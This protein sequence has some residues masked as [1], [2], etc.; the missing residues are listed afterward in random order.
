MMGLRRYDVYIHIQNAQCLARKKKSSP[1]SPKGASFDIWISQGPHRVVQRA[2]TGVFL[3]SSKNLELSGR[4]P[5]FSNRGLAGTFAE[6]NS[7]LEAELPARPFAI[8]A[9]DDLIE[10]GLVAGAFA[11]AAP[12]EADPEAEALLGTTSTWPGGV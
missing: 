5:V 11:T 4:R 12:D 7:L 6:P 2:L 1:Q 8:D 3:H 10:E 9:P